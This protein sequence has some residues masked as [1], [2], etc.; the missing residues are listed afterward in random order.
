MEI[1]DTGLGLTHEQQ[2]RLFQKFTQADSST[3]RR[4]GGTGLGLAICK[5]LVELMGGRIGLNSAPGAGSTFWFTFPLVEAAARPRP[6]EPPPSAPSGRAGPLNLRVLVAEDNLIS[7][8][9]AVA[10]LKKFGCIADVAANGRETVEFFR[11]QA[12]DLILM[13][14]HM[15]EMDG[16]EAT[17]EIRRLEQASAGCRAPLPILALTASAMMEDQSQCLH[18]GMNAV[19]TKPLRA[20]DLRQALEHWTLSVG[21]PAVPA[22]TGL[23]CPGREQP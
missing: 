7:Q 17:A 11:R 12:Y 21:P 15:P 19:L 1:I 23:A 14:C 13:D 4:F 6:A 9:F 5:R 16:Y 20:E 3:T 22:S 8:I 18:A 10:L 2:G